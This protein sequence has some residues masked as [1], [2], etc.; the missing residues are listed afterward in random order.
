MSVDVLI[1][2]ILISDFSSV[3]VLS[4]RTESLSVDVLISGIL[5]SDFSS[6][7]VFFER[8]NGVIERRRLDI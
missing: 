5:I 8:E 6:V 2:D 7:T 3:T 4:V 1:S